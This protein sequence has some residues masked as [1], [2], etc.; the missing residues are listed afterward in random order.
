VT[1]P[2]L[3]FTTVSLFGDMPTTRTEYICGLNT[4]SESRSCSGHSDTTPPT[5]VRYEY[6]P[7][8]AYIHNRDLN[9]RFE[10]EPAKR[11]YTAW[12]VNEYG[13]PKWAKLRQVEQQKRS[14]RTVHAHTETINTAERRELFDYTARRVITRNRQTRDSQVLSEFECDGWYIDPPAALSRCT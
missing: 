9:Y 7:L 6:G 14:G 8:R 3:R 11:I 4:R 2:S 1:G 13:G 10:L 12:Q 5:N